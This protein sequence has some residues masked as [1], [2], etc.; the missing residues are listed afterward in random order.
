VVEVVTSPTFTIMKQYEI[1][2]K[3]FDLMVHIDAYRIES[4]EEVEPLHLE[5]VFNRTKTVVCIEWPERIRSIIPQHSV[6]ILISI[7]EN[8]VRQVSL[9]AD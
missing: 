3:D 9:S 2:N 6:E 7:G 4:E 1:D 8:E 5:S